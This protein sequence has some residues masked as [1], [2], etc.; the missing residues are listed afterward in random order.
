M[1][2][3]AFSPPARRALARAALCLSLSL[4]F[5]AAAPASAQVEDYVTG[6]QI[7]FVGS[8]PNFGGIVGWKRCTSGESPVQTKFLRDNTAGF[9][10]TLGRCLPGEFSFDGTSLLF[11][12]G[13]DGAI[14][15][16]GFSNVVLGNT[17]DPS[18]ITELTQTALGSTHFFWTEN[19]VSFEFPDPGKIYRIPRGGG[20]PELLWDM[21]TNAIYPTD[22]AVLDTNTRVAA[23]SSDGRLWE[24]KE[25]IS[26]DPPFQLRLW[27]H[28]ERA[29]RVQAMEVHGDRLYWADLTSDGRSI[30]F[31][32]APLS[33]L[34]STQI[35]GI[36]NRPAGGLSMSEMAVTGNAIYFQ[37]LINGTPSAALRRQPLPT[38]T[39]TDAAVLTTR[40]FDLQSQAG[41]VLWGKNT[42]TI[43]RLSETAAPLTRDLRAVSLEIIQSIQGP[44]N[45]VTLVADKATFARAFARIE[46]TSSGETAL[47]LAPGMVLH[48]TDSGGNRLPNSPLY[49]TR[50][51]PVTNAIQGGNRALQEDGFW[52][53][54]PREWTQVGQVTLRAEV[55]PSRSL[56]EITRSNNSVSVTR[57]F[58]RKVPVC[59][60]MIPTVTHLGTFRRYHPSYQETFDYL[61]ALL[62]TS[63]LQVDF[64]PGD[65][66]DE[67]GHLVWEH[68]PFEFQEGDDD[69]DKVLNGLFWKKVFGS[70]GPHCEPEGGFDHYVSM[71][72]QH[73]VGWS[74]Y[75]RRGT[76]VITEGISIFMY[77]NFRSSLG[78][79]SPA[80]TQAQELSH[81]YGRWHVDC[82]DPD[83]VDTNYWYDPET[84]SDEGHLG[85]DP[86]RRILIGADEAR[87]YMSYC[88][89]EWVSPYTWHEM[90]NRISTASGFAPLLG[91]D[92]KAKAAKKPAVPAGDGGAK[93]DYPPRLITGLMGLDGEQSEVYPAITL[94]PEQAARAVAG[95]SGDGYPLEM[96]AYAGNMLI[97]TSPART[98]LPL[99]DAGAHDSKQHGFAGVLEA[100]ASTTRVAIVDPE[101]P[102][103]VLVNLEGGD[104]PPSVEVIFPEG[105]ETFSAPFTI[106]WK[107]EHNEA[108][109]DTH[110]PLAYT[111]RY[112][113][114]NGS[115]W[116]QLAENTAA[117]SLT[118]DPANL[119]GNPDPQNCLVEVTASDGLLVGT[120]QSEKFTVGNKNPDCYIFFEGDGGKSTI[121]LAHA[122]F[123]CGETVRLHGVA[124]DVEDGGLGEFAMSWSVTGP[125]N[126]FGQGAN[127]AL[128]NLPPGEYT[129]ELFAFDAF[130]GTGSATAGL[131]I[132]PR[133][134]AE[135]SGPIDVDGQ[136]SDIGY[137]GDACRT[138][139]RYPDTGNI[140][141]ARIVRLGDYLHLCVEGLEQGQNTGSTLAVIFDVNNNASS[142]PEASDRRFDIVLAT[143]QIRSYTGGG[144]FWFPDNVPSGMSGFV[145]QR[146]GRW[147]VE[148]LIGLLP[149]GGWNDQTV[150]MAIQHTARHAGGDDHLWPPTANSILPASWAKT[151]F[152]TNPDN[153]SDINNN[154]I[155][156]QW[157]LDTHGK[158]VKPGDD[159]DG[160]GQDEV[161]EYTAGTDGNDPSSFFKA[162][163][164]T[165]ASQGNK[166]AADG[167]SITW[168]T[169][170]HR[171]YE[172]WRSTDLANYYPLA[173]GIPADPTGT[174]EWTDPNPPAGRAFYQVK[175]VYFR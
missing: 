129:V 155:A 80:A 34:T 127:F 82:G 91:G 117:D 64:V 142:G 150:G 134:I 125:V 50:N 70:G 86:I 170:P 78:M 119:P 98:F 88:G 174:A 141:N 61:E 143:G 52:F 145:T 68:S 163:V 102:S 169:A 156:D 133:Y 4:P 13:S 92:A 18:G 27:T 94:T 63:R 111:V 175:A 59:M 49:P 40:I 165:A 15:R 83:N 116:V 6:A 93:A 157:E 153:P 44:A 62:P 124:H 104:N 9:F 8:V 97:A 7:D 69:K 38:G 166:A 43:S 84:L 71:I 56:S 135:A 46:A 161:T 76:D 147:I 113:P 17:P 103:E 55:N 126:G 37:T 3:S 173:S 85:F 164:K 20:S 154:G 28:T 73:S 22:L 99:L 120:D 136:A 107:G 45:D 58:L 42:S 115:T 14:I 19:P 101:N 75:A 144:T 54:I 171:S 21:S 100:D 53:T 48:G 16:T 74:G 25:V 79:P 24:I 118:V 36:E 11:S 162:Q 123:Q 114:D 90:N 66:L 139:I 172:I 160:D 30:F 112:S 81:N 77:N 168:A 39:I 67:T 140:A 105:G 128:E 51:P 1:K 149:I 167:I 5:F 96:R 151:V 152:G 130:Q 32:S 132:E 95:L 35:H 33:D 72:P 159:L 122:S 29:Q 47:A 31:R 110:G 106:E 148:V 57:T 10:R 87:D 12:V 146:D 23:I 89:P 109:T 65:N 138:E 2:R 108:F 60:V 121:N 26:G 137:E 158:L 41:W 131:T